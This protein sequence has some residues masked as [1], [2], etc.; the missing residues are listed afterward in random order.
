MDSF[1]FT[2][3]MK[4][5]DLIHTDYRLLLLLPRFGLNLGFGDKSVQECCKQHQISD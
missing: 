3:Q 4:L 5:A 2:P 1:L